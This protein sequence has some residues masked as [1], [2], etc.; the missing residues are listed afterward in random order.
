MCLL[1][2]AHPSAYTFQC[3]N[4]AKQ[5]L[6]Y[7]QLTKGHRKSLE[8][9]SNDGESLTKSCGTDALVACTKVL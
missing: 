1:F 2:T 4:C 6:N 9:Y 5:S 3:E 7:I 8:T